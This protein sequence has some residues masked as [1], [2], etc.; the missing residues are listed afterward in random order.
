M[1]VTHKGCIPEARRRV[2]RG[3]ESGPEGGLL[4]RMSEWLQVTGVEMS[5]PRAILIDTNPLLLIKDHEE[6]GRSP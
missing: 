3:E 4:G 2:L 6:E 5:A 1:A